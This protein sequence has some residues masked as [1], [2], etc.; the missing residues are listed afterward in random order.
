MEIGAFL[1]TAFIETGDINAYL[2]YKT[3]T[4]LSEEYDEKWQTLQQEGLLLSNPITERATEC[5]QFL[6]KT[7]V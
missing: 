5:S 7:T 1:W 6:Q 3:I 4:E 2:L